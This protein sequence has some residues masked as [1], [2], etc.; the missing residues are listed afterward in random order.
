MARGNLTDILIGYERDAEYGTKFK[1]ISVTGNVTRTRSRFV[2]RMLGLCRSLLNTF[3]YSSTRSYGLF[4]IGFGLFSFLLHT[5]RTYTAG[6]QIPL[7]V[8]ISSVVLSLLGI[9]LVC[10]DKQ[11]AIAMQ[12]FPLT[13]YIFF[14]FFCLK[15]MHRIKLNA[16]RNG[17]DAVLLVKP[18]VALIL[19]LLLAAFTML[20]P[21]WYI[22][23]GIGVLVYLF[24]TFISPEFSFFS[25]ILAMPYL[26]TLDFSDFILGMAVLVTFLSF[27]VKVALG[28]RVYHFEQYDLLLALFLAFVLISGIFVKGLASFGASLILVLFAMGYVLSS[29]L[30]SNRRLAD[31]LIN[32]LIIS[33]IPV[34]AHAVFVGIKSLVANGFGGFAPVSA[35]FESE[36]SLAIYLLVAAI[37][38]LYY[39]KASYHIAARLGYGLVF[40]LIFLALLS[41][42]CTWAFIAGLFGVAAYLF[43]RLRRAGPLFVGMLCFLPYLLLFVGGD[44]LRLL[45]NVP[46]IST[47]GLG[48]LADRW[49]ASFNMLLDNL[50]V[51]V[52]IGSDSFLREI[53]HYSPERYTDS[54]NLLLEIGC[55]AGVFALIA[56][57]AIILVRLVHRIAYRRYVAVSEV[58]YLSA[59]SSVAM[60]VL[61]VFGAV[62]YLFSDLTLNLLY[63]CVFG[64]G[65]AALRVAKREHDDL[66]GY[67]S[68][69]R[70]RDSSSMDIELY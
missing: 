56:F 52:G 1:S 43:T 23:L 38:T 47:L 26:P 51:G 11:L 2:R 44:T 39:I 45:D 42:A 50:F 61:F 21:M 32:A 15:R 8:I 31:C 9:P 16:A 22:M 29:S 54:A 69:G 55:E 13:D 48:D 60:C 33:A 19:G 63:W 70:S 17:D 35:T 28:K 27:A 57:L 41:T 49:S 4:L 64:I 20:V 40:V 67:Y 46:I 6:D 30:I 37:F 10:F 18:Y 68:D 62:S 53:V 5:I 14:E 25:I 59:F 24:L 36:S 66:I 12:D 3:S 7:Y 58:R 34:S 65:S